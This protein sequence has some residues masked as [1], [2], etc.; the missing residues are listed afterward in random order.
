MKD[1]IIW[2]ESMLKRGF[3]QIPNDFFKKACELKLDGVDQAIILAIAESQFSGFS[4]SNKILSQRLLFSERTIQ[5][6]IKELEKKGSIK[7]IRSK[8]SDNTNNYNIYDLEPLFVQFEALEGNSYIP[9]KSTRI[10]FDSKIKNR[11]KNIGVIPEVEI[12]PEKDDWNKIEFL[13]QEVGFTRD[14]FDAM[15][16]VIRKILCELNFGKIEEQK[17]VMEDQKRLFLR[18][19]E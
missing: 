19:L 4:P 9:T 1:K 18:K 7:V 3:C 2:P 14:M 12:E 5:S 16:P 13:A 10:E 6:R 17:I 8:K 15:S 11:R